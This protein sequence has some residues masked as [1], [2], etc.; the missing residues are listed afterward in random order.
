MHSSFVLCFRVLIVGWLLFMTGYYYY[1]SNIV[2]ISHH[3]RSMLI[4][5]SETLTKTPFDTVLPGV[6]YFNKIYNMLDGTDLLEKSGRDIYSF[7]YSNNVKTLPS[8]H[9]YLVPVEFTGI[10][11]IFPQCYKDTTHST[12][13]NTWSSTIITATESS[14]SS[15]FSITTSQAAAILST[16][17]PTAKGINDIISN[18]AFKDTKAS[19]QNGN[20]HNSKSTQIKSNEGFK[21]TYKL[22]AETSLYEAV[23][24]WDQFIDFDFKIDFMN[25]INDLELEMHNVEILDF[26]HKW[27]THS[28]GS[29]RMGAV[30]EE[31][32]YLKSSKEGYN[33]N[34]F[35]QYTKTKSNEFIFWS[36]SSSTTSSTSSA[37]SY[38][39]DLW[40]E[41]TNYKCE[42][43][44]GTS[45]ECG[46]MTGSGYF[47]KTS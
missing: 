46:G 36:S 40:Y 44:C 23:V 47:F 25:A 3:R 24:A 22:S 26:I 2:Q 20:S 43:E 32:I 33:Y 4:S 16:F 18:P 7:R 15:D 28:I 5:G 30:C 27:G 8:Q 14:K 21:K 17:F 9:S 41:V 37:G 39:N 38:Q 19:I 6:S 11:N 10:P 29:A 34:N 42:G 35:Y 45:Q 31:S 13:T 1:L 12:M